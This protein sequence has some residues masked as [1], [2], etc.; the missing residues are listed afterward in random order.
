MPTMVSGQATTSLAKATEASLRGAAALHGRPSFVE[1]GFTTELDGTHSHPVARVMPT[2][3]RGAM[4]NTRL[5]VEHE[6]RIRAR[7]IAKA[8]ADIFKER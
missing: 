7:Y 1:V 4:V 2:A 5:D 8:C 6:F 3:W